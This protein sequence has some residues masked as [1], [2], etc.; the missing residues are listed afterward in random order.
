MEE[1]VQNAEET[2]TPNQSIWKGAILLFRHPD[3]G[4][5]I[6][7]EN[8]QVKHQLWMLG[9]LGVTRA[10]ARI[11]YFDLSF[12]EAIGK[13]ILYAIAGV[14][15]GWFGIWIMSR[16][17]HAFNLWLK[18]HSDPSYLLTIFC[19]A[20]LPLLLFNLII[21][22]STFLY[23][24]GIEVIIFVTYYGGLIY[25]FCLMLIGNKKLSGLPFFKNLLAVS[26]PIICL[27]LVGFVFYILSDVI[28]TR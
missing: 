15:V 26:I 16:I 22:L 19:F 13:T 24:E 23:F 5:D 21:I 6:I 17:T 10:I 14:L 18:G 1:T 9:I 28:S 4:F 11:D 8:W 20:W 25:T 7:L 12:A 27:I 2:S 3:K